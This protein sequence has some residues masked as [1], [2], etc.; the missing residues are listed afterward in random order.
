MGYRQANLTAIFVC[1]ILEFLKISH[2]NGCGREDCFLTTIRVRDFRKFKN[3]AHQNS[4]EAMVSHTLLLVVGPV[5]HPTCWPLA[6]DRTN[7]LCSLP[8]SQIWEK[9]ILL[10]FQYK[11]TNFCAEDQFMVDLLVGNN[12]S[13]CLWAGMH[14]GVRLGLI[15]PNNQV[16]LTT[17]E[18]SA[19]TN[20][21]PQL[22]QV[23]HHGVGVLQADPVQIVTRVVLLAMR[24]QANTL[25][26][27]PTAKH[28][29]AH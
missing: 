20:G 29:P 8:G 6:W 14:P 25:S 10:I 23:R 27:A 11:R 2:W 9:I 7:H 5:G 1:S 4:S 3:T 22:G 26:T 12:S 24:L 18:R 17:K 21:A 19:Q 15:S 13:Q 16:Y 28:R